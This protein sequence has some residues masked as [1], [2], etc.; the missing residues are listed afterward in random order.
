MSEASPIFEVSRAPEVG[1]SFGESRNSDVLI[2]VPCLNEEAHLPAL[3][4]GLLGNAHGALV[5]VADGGSVDASREIVM[6]LGRKHPNLVL[7][8][9]PQRIQSA[10]VNLAARRFGAGRNWLLRI[11]AHAHYPDGFLDNLRLSAGS[12]RA[13]S[14]VVPMVTSG[15]ACFQ[16]AA[17]A[18]QNSVLGTGGA[19]HRH[20][21][22]GQWVDH[23]HHAL[24]DLRLFMAVG[25]Y[26]EGF[27]ANED[28]ELDRRLI[29]AGGRIWLEPQAAIT[30]FPR[31]TMGALFRQY[32]KYGI[33]RAR[34]L[35]RHPAPVKLRQML[36]LAVVP[37]I[38]VA[39]TGL[40]L[41]LLRVEA[42]VLVL[43]MLCWLVGALVAGA[44]LGWRARSL[45]DA[46]AG[47]AALTMHAG[48]SLGFIEEALSRQRLPN[49]PQP[50]GFESVAL[51]DMNGGRR[52]SGEVLI[53]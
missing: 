34:N 42:L 31:R 28:S 52:V 25:G 26:D 43:P 15:T 21:G 5:V 10:A 12:M 32:R 22:R 23:G 49:P 39:L 3:L 27:A 9:N 7:L 1:P 36:P 41:A 18:A 13:S 46:G 45:C 47:V 33:G 20:L 11:D 17:A 8:D 4:G 14:V 53:A 44:M 29:A 6:A 37:S 16:K 40:A 48:W 30:Y 19:P 35:K 50:L 51:P 38:L 2:V 24:F